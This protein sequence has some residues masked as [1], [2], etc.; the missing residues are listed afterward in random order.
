MG[1]FAASPR[2]RWVIKIVLKFLVAFAVKYDIGAMVAL[3]TNGGYKLCK[4]Q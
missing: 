1:P 3:L 4:V 2:Q